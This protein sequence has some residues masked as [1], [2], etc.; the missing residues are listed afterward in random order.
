MAEVGVSISLVGVGVSISF[1]NDAMVS[2]APDF[3]DRCIRI[4]KAADKR[5]GP[6]S[7]RF[8]KVCLNLDGS[9]AINSLAASVAWRNEVF[10]FLHHP[11]DKKSREVG[12]VTV[13]DPQRKVYSGMAYDEVQAA[14]ELPQ[15]L[16][17]HIKGVLK[18]HELRVRHARAALDLLEPG[19]PPGLAQR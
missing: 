6:F 17:I 7:I 9:S 1:E 16:L 15:L 4:V 19:H 5:G 12:I 8:R 18:K 11:L 14:R 3:V 13:Y 2:Y 10:A